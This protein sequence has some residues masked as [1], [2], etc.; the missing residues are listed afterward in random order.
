MLPYIFTHLASQT[1]CTLNGQPVD[2]GQVTKAVGGFFGAF[3]L[4]FAAAA[5]LALVNLVF[6]IISLVHVLQHEDVKDRLVWIIIILIVPLGAIIYFFAVLLPYKKQ[7]P[8]NA[9]A[10]S[11]VMPS[12]PYTPPV[13]VAPQNTTSS[14]STPPAGQGN[15]SDGNP[16]PSA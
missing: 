5:V 11:S 16:T 13:P 4:I 1:T 7:H 2:C 3:F 12:Q 8:V 10:A 6:W 15:D 9:P 14:P